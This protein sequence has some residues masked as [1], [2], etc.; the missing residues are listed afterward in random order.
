MPGPAQGRVARVGDG[1]R[2]VKISRAIL[3]LFHDIW[4]TVV[5]ST[6]FPPQLPEVLERIHT[7]L[8][9]FADAFNDPQVLPPHRIFYHT[10]AL[11][12]DSVPVNARPNR[13]N[14]Q[15]KEF[16]TL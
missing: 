4:E 8:L 16:W 15:Q 6:T 11:L 13:Y 10:I 12:P 3:I 7:I 14:P 2:R 9:D 5:V 1:L